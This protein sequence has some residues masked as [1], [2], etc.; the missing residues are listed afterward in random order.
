MQLMVMLSNGIV[1]WR[2]L[3]QARRDEQ[4]I[5]MPWCA[6][7]VSG[8]VI[9]SCPMQSNAKVCWRGWLKRNLCGQAFRRLGVPAALRQADL[10]CLLIAGLV[11]PPNQRVQSTPLRVERD[12]S[13]F[14]S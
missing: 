11:L 3:T 14:E 7:L 5:R 10:L 9:S 4:C 12:R 1:C 8:K 2:D 6:D 13:Y